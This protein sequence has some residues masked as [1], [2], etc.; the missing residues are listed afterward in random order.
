MLRSYDSR[1]SSYNPTILESISISWATPGVFAPVRVGAELM[2]EDLISAVDGF[3]NPTLQAIKETHEAF[4][5]DQRVSCLLN[6]GAGRPPF[7]ALSVGGR[8]LAQQTTRDTEITAEQLKSRYINI[9]IYFRLSVDWNL[10]S[11]DAQ[12]M[13][14]ERVGRI[15]AH[16]STY[17][18]TQDASNTLERCV[19]ASRRVGYITLEDLC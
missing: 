1:H 7:R 8:D 19:G 14:E 2:S 18:E 9:G 5:Q 12:E 3:N 4:G 17:L 11:G 16:T 6:I 15:D 10:S 13:L